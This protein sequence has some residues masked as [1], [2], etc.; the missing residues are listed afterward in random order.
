MLVQGGSV[1]GVPAF[2]HFGQLALGAG[3]A[4]QGAAAQ[5]HFC[6]QQFGQVLGQ[7]DVV[8][9]LIPQLG[10]QGVG[11]QLGNHPGVHERLNGLWQVDEGGGVAQ[12][13]PFA[14][15]HFPQQGADGGGAGLAPVGQHGH[16]AAAVPVLVLLGAAGLLQQQFK[17]AGVADVFGLNGAGAAQGLAFTVG[18]GDADAVL[19]AQAEGGSVPV[20]RRATDDAGQPGQGVA[21]G[22][23]CGVGDHQG[24]VGVGHAL[25]AAT[26]QVQGAGSGWVGCALA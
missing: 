22:L 23:A 5:V 15:A 7:G 11:Q 6:P 21:Q 17:A 19:Q 14:F 8:A 4:G 24:F 2:E 1:G 25:V 10:G 20:H 16:A 18:P 12:V 13:G 9:L 3:G 26:G